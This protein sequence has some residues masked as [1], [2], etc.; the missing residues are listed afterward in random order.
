M[1]TSSGDVI[2]A[3]LDTGI[4]YNHPDLK[5]NMWTGSSGEHGFNVITQTQDPMDDNGHG[6]HCAGII[7][8]VGNNGVGD[9][10]SPGRQN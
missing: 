1:T 7:G 4:D 8:A 5:S 2:V 10:V 3:V 6:T 9:L